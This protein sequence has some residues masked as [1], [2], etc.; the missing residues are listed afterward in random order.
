MN[1]RDA[2]TK[3]LNADEKYLN[4]L[5]FTE[6]PR[7]YPKDVW[8]NTSLPVV[9]TYV[10]DG[11]ESQAVGFIINMAKMLPNNTIL[12]YNLGLDDRGFKLVC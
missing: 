7:L 4:V 1:L 12:I 8:K 3:T 9:V 5:G 11:Q 6:E 10:R 2:E